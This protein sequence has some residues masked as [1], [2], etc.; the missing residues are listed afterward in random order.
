MLERKRDAL[1]KDIA[2]EKF[3]LDKKIIL[4]ANGPKYFKKKNISPPR[5]EGAFYFITELK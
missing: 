5:K 1:K 4:N 3:K 2:I